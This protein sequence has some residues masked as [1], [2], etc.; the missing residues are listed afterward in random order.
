MEQLGTSSGTGVGTTAPSATSETGVGHGEV[1]NAAK[2][3]MNG[4]CCYCNTFQYNPHVSSCPTK[5]TAECNINSC[6]GNPGFTDCSNFVSNAYTKAGCKSPG[7]TTSAI[8]SNAHTLDKNSLKAGD[9]IVRRNSSGGHVVMCEDDGC[10]TVIHA[11][12]KDKGIVERSS[13]YY[14][15][16]SWGG[17]VVSASSFCSS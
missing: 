13:S 11:A 12:G 3:L 9:L 8:I 7:T 6:S 4:G 16:S 14:L 17:K 10:T 5:H 1:V 15:D 2:Q